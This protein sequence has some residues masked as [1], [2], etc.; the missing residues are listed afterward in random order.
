MADESGP[1]TDHN[2]RTIA[3]VPFLRSNTKVRIR[4]CQ[5]CG[6]QF[7]EAGYNRIEN[8]KPEYR[9]CDQYIALRVMEE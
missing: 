7:A 9:Y 2:F 1:L 4:E 6:F 8:M 3:Q 5:N